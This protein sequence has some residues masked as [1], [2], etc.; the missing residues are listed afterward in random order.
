MDYLAKQRDV[1]KYLHDQTIRL[2]NH[3]LKATEIAEHLT[4]PR[5]L[6]HEWSVRGYYGTLSH[7]AKSIYQ[8]YIGWYDANPAHLNP[9]PLTERSAKLL[10]YMGGEDAAIAKAR[11]DFN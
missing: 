11:E 6:E 7:N 4:L 5:S 10:A 8:H 3:G 1:Y 9:L 2:I